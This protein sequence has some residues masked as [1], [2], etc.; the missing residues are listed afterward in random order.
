M[1]N[2][3]LWILILLSTGCGNNACGNNFTPCAQPATN[4]NNFNCG[5]NQMPYECNPQ[6]MC[7]NPCNTTCNTPTVLP[8]FGGGNDCWI[9][10]LIILSMCGTQPARNNCNCAPRC[11]C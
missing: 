11:F 10:W 9:I 7:N 5:T 1:N 2:S 3:L 4:C 6:P 8:S